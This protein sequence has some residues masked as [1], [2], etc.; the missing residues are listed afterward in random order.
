MEI[1]NIQS[2]D[3]TD[4]DNPAAINQVAYNKLLECIDSSMSE[5]KSNFLRMTG[6]YISAAAKAFA[7]TDGTTTSTEVKIYNA[8]D[9]LSKVPFKKKMAVAG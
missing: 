6:Y 1:R 5:F 2:F 3:V 7:K 9:K 4:R 8:I